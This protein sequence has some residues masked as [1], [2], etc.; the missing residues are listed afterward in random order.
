[1]LMYLEHVS[2]LISDMDA[3]SVKSYETVKSILSTKGRSK[4]T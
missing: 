2:L 1:M 3:L 4:R